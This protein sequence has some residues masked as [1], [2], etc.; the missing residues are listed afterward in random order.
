LAVGL[1]VLSVSHRSEVSVHLAVGLVVLSVSHRSE[2]SVHLAV[3]LSVSH[4]LELTEQT[5]GE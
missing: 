2:V 3:V 1:A 4:H 5:A